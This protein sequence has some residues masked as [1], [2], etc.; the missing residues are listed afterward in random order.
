[1]GLD[2]GLL[3]STVN[4]NTIELEWA[5]GIYVFALP[6]ERI[7]ELQRKCSIGI[8]GLFNRLLKGCL[9]DPVT[10]KV[11]VNPAAGEFY[12]VDIIE[13]LRQGLIGGGKGEVD[14]LQVNVTPI[15]TNQLIKS[16]VLDRPL[17]DNWPVAVSVLTACIMGYEPPKKDG[18]AEERAEPQQTETLTEA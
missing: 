13:T 9:K 14:G 3:S 8:G 2:A 11:F 18:P 15:L 4:R 17:S 5:D 10:G 6:L 12:A 7:D 1:V 16:Y